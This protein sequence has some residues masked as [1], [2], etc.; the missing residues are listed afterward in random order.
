MTWDPARME[1]AERALERWRRAVWDADSRMIC[2]LEAMADQCIA[3]LEVT[4]D[5]LEENGSSSDVHDRVVANR[6]LIERWVNR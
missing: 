1:H 4:S 5:L 3:A 6:E 2:R